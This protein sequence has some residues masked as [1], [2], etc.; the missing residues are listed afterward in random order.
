MLSA[1]QPTINKIGFTGYRLDE[2]TGLDYAVNR[3]YDPS[4]GRFATQDPLTETGERMG[5]PQGL[6][7]Y[8][9]VTSN[10]LR[11]VDPDGLD[12]WA[13]NLKGHLQLMPG[14]RPTPGA[15]AVPGLVPQE[16]DF[17]IEFE[18]LE[19]NLW[20]TNKVEAKKGS[21]LLAHADGTATFLRGPEPSSPEGGPSLPGTVPIFAEDESSS[22]DDPLGSSFFGWGWK[23]GKV[24]FPNI[25]D[26][27]EG[28]NRGVGFGFGV[29]SKE[30]L[31]K[32][33][34]SHV[35]LTGQLAGNLLVAAT[36]LWLET[37][38]GPGAGAFLANTGIG[39]PFAVPAAVAVTAAGKAI[40]WHAVIRAGLTTIVI[41]DKLTTDLAALANKFS[42]NANSDSSSGSNGKE[43][44]ASGGTPSSE[45]GP[46]S[47]ESEP[48]AGNGPPASVS[49]R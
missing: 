15:G 35:N 23:A 2:E 18:A 10:P 28:L 14:E 5:T 1:Q 37:M 20:G 26:F 41:L 34:D 40:K 30:Y 22:L 49:T 9:Y 6:N 36:G 39:A 29:S 38:G 32:T 47:P 46:P 13:Y 11:Y 31:P 4:R 42:Q 17:P 3:M 21:R 16:K 48:S 27:I 8:G 33:T 19:Y 12:Y 43:P 7:L 24:L 44:S 25:A 45:G